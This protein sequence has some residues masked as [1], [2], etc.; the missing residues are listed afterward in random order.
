[1]SKN[2]FDMFRE[3]KESNNTDCESMIKFPGNIIQIHKINFG[4]FNNYVDKTRYLGRWYWNKMTMECRSSIISVKEFLPK[5]RHVV[6][7][8][9][10]MT[11]SC[12]S[13]L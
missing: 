8:W 11:K 13:S 4:A 3:I 7:R 12:Q 6:D 1:M 5:C 9:S 10:I 2:L